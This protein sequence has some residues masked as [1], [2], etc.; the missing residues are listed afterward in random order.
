MNEYGAMFDNGDAE[1]DRHGYLQWSVFGERTKSFAPSSKDFM[2][3]YHVVHL[4]ELMKRMRADGVGFTDSIEYGAFVHALD[5]DSN[6]LHCGSP[7]TRCSRACT[8]ALR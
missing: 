3:N 5:L 2:I 1:A 7:S 4:E 6:K 8:R